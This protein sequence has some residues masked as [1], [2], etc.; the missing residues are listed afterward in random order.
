MRVCGCPKIVITS[1]RGARDKRKKKTMRKRIGKREKNRSLS[2]LLAISQYLVWFSL[3]SSL[4]REN[5]VVLSLKPWAMWESLDLPTSGSAE[6]F[7]RARGESGRF[8]MFSAAKASERAPI[9]GTGNEKGRTLKKSNWTWAIGESGRVNAFSPSLSPVPD[10]RFLFLFL[11][12]PPSGRL[13]CT[14]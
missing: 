4:S 5:F 6:I 10:S 12:A 11:R 3:S 14:G 8:L 2:R 13:A 9:T 7:S 1:D